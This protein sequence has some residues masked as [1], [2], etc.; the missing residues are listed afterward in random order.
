MPPITVTKFASAIANPVQA[1]GFRFRDTYTTEPTAALTLHNVQPVNQSGGN[2]GTY[3]SVPSG[4]FFAYLFRDPFRSAVLFVANP[5]GKTYT[6]SAVFYNQNTKTNSSSFPILA[7]AG[8]T[9]QINVN[10]F[11]DALIGNTG[12]LYPHGNTLFTGVANS[13]GFV[14]MDLN[15][16]ITFG[17][18]VSDTAAYV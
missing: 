8:E 6:Y 10:Y 2:A 18:S 1:R 4:T 5:G 17:Q 9:C 3:A 7:G 16:I 14:W 15:A 13:I 11:T 12:Y